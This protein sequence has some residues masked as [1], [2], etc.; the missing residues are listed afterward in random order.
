M[1]TCFPLKPKQQKHR[2]TVSRTFFK[3]YLWC[4]TNV[5]SLTTDS[6]NLSCI[7]HNFMCVYRAM[8]KIGKKKQKHFVKVGQAFCESWSRS[9]S[10]EWYFIAPAEFVSNMKC[11]LLVNGIFG[12]RFSTCKSDQNWSEMR[13]CLLRVSYFFSMNLWQKPKWA[14]WWVMNQCC[15]ELNKSPFALSLMHMPQFYF[16]F[17]AATGCSFVKSPQHWHSRK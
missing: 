17:A 5:W 3:S 7:L 2:K 12:E 10:L 8:Q 1:Q 14:K 15:T 11:S 9:V 4:F 6:K 13:W 16:V